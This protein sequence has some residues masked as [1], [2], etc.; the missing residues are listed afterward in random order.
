ML[1]KLQDYFCGA[2]KLQLNTIRTFGRTSFLDDLLSISC[3]FMKSKVPT[4]AQR[5]RYSYV[6]RA[7]APLH[8]AIEELYVESLFQ[9]NVPV[10]RRRYAVR[11]NR[12]FADRF[13]VALSEALE[14]VYATIKL[15]RNGQGS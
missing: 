7:T 6:N 11:W 10:Q 8:N 14:D 1:S 3:Q 15:G 9:P 4:C 5:L 12:L 2:V 13:F